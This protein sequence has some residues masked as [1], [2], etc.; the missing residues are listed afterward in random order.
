MRRAAAFALLALGCAW[1]IAHAALD[2]FLVVQGRVDYARVLGGWS[3]LAFEFDSHR[4]LIGDG[5]EGVR[6]L[7]DEP[8]VLRYELTD[9]TANL[10]L[11][12]RGLALD[13]HRLRG[14]DLRIE[15]SAPATLHLLFDAPGELRQWQRRIELGAGWNRLRVDLAD[16]S[17]HAHDGSAEAAWGGPRARVGEFRLHLAGAA[18]LVIALDHLR[19]VDHLGTSEAPR[20]V[21]WLSAHQARARLRAGTPLV[22]AKNAR[23]G[24]LLD[25]WTDTPER[26]LSLRDQLRAIDSDALFWPAWRDPPDAA[27]VATAPDGWS[28]PV[29]ALITYALLALWLRVRARPGRRLDALAELAIG[30]GPLLAI[31]LG[32]GLAEQPAPGLLAWIALALL[33]QLS[34]LRLGNAGWR[35]EAGAWVGML[36]YT[37]PA[38]LALLAVA[39]MTAHWQAQGSQRVLLYLPFVLLQ[40]SLLLGFLWPRA[41]LLAGRHG[42][43]LA[44]AL[45]A[46]AHAPNFALMVATLVI[47]PAWISSYRRGRAWLPVLCSHYALGLL[48]ISCLP[49]DWLYSAEAGL[50]Y[51]QVR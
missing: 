21:V 33:F 32:L 9:G 41:R 40:Q 4:E 6:R 30:H 51:F 42:A 37:L 31:T 47:A 17:W 12:L 35:G 36:R 14:L 8:G 29:P 3:R 38:A 46:L 28:P 7:P 27:A 20:G 15:A 25:V 24:V 16:L 45:F 44:A 48:A 11:N 13:A 19:F 18:G 49:P 1:A 39:W 43:W 23:A 50:R 5:I 10:R 2:R 34:G 26:A 22:E